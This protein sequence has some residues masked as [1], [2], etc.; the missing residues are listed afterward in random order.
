MPDASGTPRRSR[1][2]RHLKRVWQIITQT[3]AGLAALLGAWQALRSFQRTVGLVTLTHL[4][5]IAVVVFV[6]I[7]AGSLHGIFWSRVEG[8]LGWRFGAGGGDQLPSGFSA[9]VLSVTLTLALFLAPGLVDLLGEALTDRRF[10]PTGHW[11]YGW[12]IFP[13]G[14]F[15]HL[16]MY[17]A[18]SFG[19]KGLR[20]RLMPPVGD[21][22]LPRAFGVE[23]LYGLVY[24]STI[25][26]PY[27]FAASV[28]SETL[29]LRPTIGAVLFMIAMAGF[30]LVRYPASLEDATWVQ[31]RG[32]FAGFV[33]AT[34]LAGGM[35]F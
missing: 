1:Q 23:V 10:L 4:E 6:G 18:E 30:I 28:S 20:Q 34:T 27:R 5:Q 2:E 19:V 7:V 13:G 11:L 24:F 22:G 33:L 29:L 25:A 17:G 21:V 26:V 12:V 32:F 3:T 14:A 31:V 8:S 15:G 35:L 16:L 9:I